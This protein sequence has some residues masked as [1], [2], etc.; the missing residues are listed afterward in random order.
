MEKRGFGTGRK[1]FVKLSR[2]VES[3]WPPVP[4]MLQLCTKNDPSHGSAYRS[5]EET[6]RAAAPSRA[7]EGR[8]VTSL[9]MLRGGGRV[10]TRPGGW[11]AL[12]TPMP[13]L[14]DAL[15]S[16]ELCVFARSAATGAGFP[17]Y[18]PLCKLSSFILG[19]HPPKKQQPP[20]HP[21]AA[22]ETVSPRGHTFHLGMRSFNTQ[23]IPLANSETLGQP[24][25]ELT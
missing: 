19:R 7:L 23:T 2:R 5:L 20:F 25:G 13:F 11:G 24:G 15:G 1:V 4:T 6:T 12:L 9:P 21:G 3:P 17:R 8:L 10:Q 18:P 22:P 16:P 14:Q